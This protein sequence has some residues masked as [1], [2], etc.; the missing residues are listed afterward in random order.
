MDQQLL[1]SLT[2][3]GCPDIL[4]S[5]F[6]ESVNCH[7]HVLLWMEKLISC[8]S[9]SKTKKRQ[10]FYNCWGKT[11]YVFQNLFCHVEQLRK[12]SVS[13]LWTFTSETSWTVVVLFT[14][15]TLPFP[16]ASRRYG[17]E[18]FWRGFSFI[19]VVIH[20]TVLTSRP[21]NPVQYCPCPGKL[22]WDC[23][24]LTSLL[25]LY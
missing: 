10:Q 20:L 4:V 21:L 5:G 16:E 22:P 12:W 18:T 2:S 9:F 19:F 6:L 17:K 8:L 23:E 1:Q 25:L 11:R 14:R 24:S 15:S 3:Y 13:Q 7:I